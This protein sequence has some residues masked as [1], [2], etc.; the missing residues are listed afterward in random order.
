[1]SSISQLFCYFI[2]LQINR[3]AIS[4]VDCSVEFRF[5]RCTWINAGLDVR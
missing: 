4:T 2:T 1:M 3:D 5:S